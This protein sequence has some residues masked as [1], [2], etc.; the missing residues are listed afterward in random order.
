MIDEGTTVIVVELI[1]VGVTLGD[2]VGIDKEA[3]VVVVFVG[4]GGGGGGGGGGGVGVGFLIGAAVAKATGRAG[5]A[6]IE[7]WLA[8]GIPCP[9]VVGGT[10]FDCWGAAPTGI[11][12]QY[13]LPTY[14]K[15]E[16]K[17]KFL[18][19]TSVCNRIYI[20]NPNRI[21]LTNKI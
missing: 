6:G 15:K 9:T 14:L 10:A 11:S 1:F 18:P 17:T 20:Q 5:W 7:L 12:F 2:G 21:I 13:R 3:V 4:A 16:K 19:K 8:I